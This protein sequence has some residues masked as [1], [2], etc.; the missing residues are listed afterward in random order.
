M[1]VLR[2]LRSGSLSRLTGRWLAAAGLLCLA[3]FDQ[4]ASAASTRE[5]PAVIPG[6]GLDLALDIPQTN[7]TSMQVS[8]QIGVTGINTPITKVVVKVT[9]RHSAPKDLE[10]YVISPQPVN[11][12][13][14]AVV[15]ANQDGGRP[16]PLNLPP[17]TAFDPTI[18]TGYGAVTTNGSN[19]V[20]GVQPAILDDDAVDNPNIG[21]DDP[22]D[23]YAPLNDGPD[24]RAVIPP[25]T[26]RT[27]DRGAG[28]AVTKLS[29]FIGLKDDQVNGAWTLVIRQNGPQTDFGQLVS[30]S[31]VISQESGYTWTGAGTTPNWSD[32]ANWLPAGGPTLTENGVSLVFPAIAA[33]KV[34]IN[35]LAPAQA[36]D[37]GISQVIIEGDYSITSAGNAV[38]YQDGMHF[39]CNQGDPIWN[40][41]G[42]TRG[43]VTFDVDNTQNVLL[44]PPRLTVSGALT[45]FAGTPVVHTT[46]A[47]DGNATA[48]LAVGN[49]ITGA[50]SITGGVLELDDAGALGAA[51][52][53]GAGVTVGLGGT[54]Q[55]AGGITL[56]KALNLTGLGAQ[57]QTVPLTSSTPTIG[58]LNGLTGTNS[59]IN[60]VALVTANTALGASAGQLTVAPAGTA[61]LTGIGLVKYGAGIV[62]IVPALP[63]ANTQVDVEGGAL[64]F[65]AANSIP[66][67]S[68]VI[69]N[70]GTL[71][72]LGAASD[73]IGALSLTGGTVATGT[74]TLTLIAGSPL[75]LNPSATT[76]VISGNLALP[77]LTTF[78][79][80]DGAAATDLDVQ[81]NVSGAGGVSKVGAG[82]MILSGNN[83]YAG[84]GGA[85]TRLSAGTLLINTNTTAGELLMTGGVLGGLNG[86]VGT[87]TATGGVI[88]PGL[89]GAIGQLNCTTF[90]LSGSAVYAPDVAPAS[91]SGD[92]LHADSGGDDL[93]GV[94]I[95]AR[96]LAAGS[97]TVTVLTS[98]GYGASRFQGLPNNTPGIT[99]NGNASVDLTCDSSSV[100]FSASRY[101]VN[102]DA[103][104]ADITLVRTDVTGSISVGVA[105]VEGSARLALDY[106]TPPS[107]VAT[108]AAGAA[109]ATFTIP[110]IANLISDGDKDLFLYITPQTATA[111]APPSSAQLVI[112]DNSHHPSAAKRCGLGG[113][114][115]VLILMLAALGRGLLALR[116]RLRRR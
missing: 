82:T 49:T 35:D 75:S 1:T 92:V 38:D 106:S 108:F 6:G 13:P 107:T 52:P 7:P 31:L 20:T 103:G 60:S 2:P 16:R 28:G 21:T 70:G 99:Y 56:D 79:V 65:T 95:S 84:A 43:S 33:Q 114:A 27:T 105:L 77:G 69:V 57:D 11:G 4:Q 29:H 115:T 41:P 48:V 110:L 55:L 97:G 93:G 5:Y 67:S 109:T 34:N 51:P 64:Q 68:P 3:W 17:L 88:D 116:L 12:S 61:T 58:A 86:R 72:Y 78:D 40:V 37:F 63:A 53:T 19:V 85:A 98:G 45:E 50:T 32:G 22:V 15:I 104:T 100:S 74:G 89:P 80:A 81:A 76:S 111:A 46:V 101:A 36:G 66:D 54:L 83:T 9:I 44:P 23:S 94:V 10:L 18:R 73:A 91:A 39:L 14:V 113:G 25:G 26:H 112:V 42:R 24:P 71:Q 90:T 102:K 96:R 62:T 47:K 8:H 87:I 30:W 59:V